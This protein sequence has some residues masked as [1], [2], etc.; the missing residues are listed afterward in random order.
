MT[1]TGVNIVKQNY[2]Y[3]GSTDDHLYMEI[4]ISIN[5]NFKDVKNTKL[6]KNCLILL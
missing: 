4:T 2:L 6:I 3:T 1:F 5:Q